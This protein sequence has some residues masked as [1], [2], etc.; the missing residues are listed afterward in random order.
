MRREAEKLIA[1]LVYVDDALVGYNC[2]QL[3]SSVIQQLMEEFKMRDL[4]FPTAFVG[5][6]IS[7]VPTGF[8]ISQAGFAKEILEFAGMADC[9]AVSTPMETNLKLARRTSAEPHCRDFH[10]YRQLVGALL[11]Y[12]NSRPDLCFAVATLCKFVADPSALHW[13]ALVRLLQFVKGTSR[14]GILY[15]FDGP[16]SLVG[17]ADSGWK[18]DPDD[19]KSM[20]GYC[21]LLHGAVVVYGSRK[22]DRVALSTTEAEYYALS[23]ATKEALWCRQVLDQFG[24]PIGTAGSTVIYQDNLKTIDFANNNSSHTRMSHIPVEAHL[25]RDEIVS[26]NVQVAPVSSSNMIADIFTKPLPKDKFRQFARAL[27][28]GDWTSS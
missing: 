14:H 12:L 7:K 15:S 2:A 21:F 5:L 28:V 11:W 26:G 9:N 24:F 6:H 1:I 16:N 27:G 13:A 3:G 4:G 8:V 22:Q 19:G 18:T 10:L 20:T 25:V 23:A 17:F